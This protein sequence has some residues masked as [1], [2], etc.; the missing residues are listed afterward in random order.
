MH[1]LAS[2]VAMS[3]FVGSVAM[4]RFAGTVAMHGLTGT[5]KT[6]H[7]HSTLKMAAMHRFAGT[8]AMYSLSGRVAMRGLSDNVTVHR[9]AGN[10]AMD[11]LAVT[12]AMQ[13]LDDT[14]AMHRVAGRNINHFH[15]VHGVWQCYRI[16]IKLLKTSLFFTIRDEKEKKEEKIDQ[17]TGAEINGRQNIAI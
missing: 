9:L 7:R 14:V 2:T 13:C 1:H 10:V 5:C 6:V 11:R 8:V 16:L 12:V 4:H 17:P 15:E 3:R